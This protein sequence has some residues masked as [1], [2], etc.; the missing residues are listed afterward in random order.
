MAEK[1]GV[2][3]AT[4]VHVQFL[5]DQTALRF[6]QR[7]DGKPVWNSTVAPFKGANQRGFFSTLAVR[8]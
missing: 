7:V 5:T 1:G 2:Q 8:A 6:T 3:V 4:S